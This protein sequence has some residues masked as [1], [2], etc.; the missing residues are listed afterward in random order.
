MIRHI[1]ILLHTTA[2]PTQVIDGSNLWIRTDNETIS[3]VRK[4]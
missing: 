2:A 4:K 1:L 3:T